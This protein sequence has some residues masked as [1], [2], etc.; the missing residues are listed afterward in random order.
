MIRI[1][2][3]Q[4][5]LDGE[6]WLVIRENRRGWS[7]VAKCANKYEA[8]DVAQDLV[9]DDPVDETAE[10]HP[11]DRH[12]RREAAGMEPVGGG[13][14]HTVCLTRPVRNADAADG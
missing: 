5:R 11:E 2:F 13:E 14:R 10:A 7:V 12:R 4:D 9:E 8:K 6:Q 3:D 1:E